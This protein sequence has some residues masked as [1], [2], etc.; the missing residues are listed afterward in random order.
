LHV[1]CPNLGDRQRL[2]ARLEDILDRRW[3][4]NQG[5]YARALEERLAEFLGVKHCIAVCNATVGLQ[6]VAQSLGLRGEVVLPSFTFPATAHAMALEG[7]TPVFCDVDR[8]THNIDPH[9]AERLIGPRTAA[10]VGVHLWGN[11]CDVAALAEIAARRRVRLVYDAAHALGCTH[12][13]QMIGSF[14]DAEV[15]SFHATKFVNSGEGGAI[16]TNDDRL[17]EACRR[18]RS[19]GLDDGEVVELGTNAKMCE[20][21]AALGLTSLESADEFM[22]KNAENFAAY[23]AALG[24]CRGLSLK[25]PTAGQ[26]HNRQYVVV[27]VDPHEAGR[28][29]DELQA[30]LHASN[31]MAKRYFWP[32]C[33]RMPPYAAAHAARGT[34]LPHTE[35]LCERLLQL[36]TGTAVSARDIGRIGE[37][38]RRLTT[39]QRRAA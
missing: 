29:R 1:G 19:F 30:A 12:D 14:G 9:A 10:I 34:A 22:A 13:G 6:I 7:L 32:G 33:H 25:A 39:K 36:P 28:S 31:V 17:A 15:F 26:R 8:A 3:L 20:F 11:P 21:S 16:T 23:E 35:R 5:P 27:E 24:S 2:F 37:L 38:L 4:S 18:R